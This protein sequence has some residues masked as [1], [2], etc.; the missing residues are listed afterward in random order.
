M[1]W[2]I[3]GVAFWV[4]IVVIGYELFKWFMKEVPKRDIPPRIEQLLYFLV[5]FIAVVG[6]IA[7]I[8]SGEELLP[9]PWRI[10]TSTTVVR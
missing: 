2:C 1:L 6:F 8:V 5:A 10:H 4:L 3:A 7:C 9:L